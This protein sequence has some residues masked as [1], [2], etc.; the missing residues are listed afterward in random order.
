MYFLLIYTLLYSMNYSEDDFILYNE[1]E[2]L[3]VQNND[4][5]GLYGIISSS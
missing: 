4:E 2:H 5:E 3:T 1:S